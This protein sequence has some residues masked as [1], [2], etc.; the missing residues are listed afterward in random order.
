MYRS[1]RRSPHYM[2]EF[3]RPITGINAIGSGRRGTAIDIFTFIPKSYGC[4]APTILVYLYHD[5]KAIAPLHVYTRGQ[6]V[7]ARHQQMLGKM[8]NVRT[9]VPRP[10]RTI[11]AVYR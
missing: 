11:I 8:E 5:D 10:A 9:A 2:Y 6:H 4:C 1:P 7:G 3:D